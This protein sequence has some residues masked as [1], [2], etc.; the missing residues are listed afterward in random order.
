MCLPP[1]NGDVKGSY[2]EVSEGS[3]PEGQMTW[4]ILHRDLPGYT[5]DNTIQINYVFADGIQTV[6]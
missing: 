5:G 2:A 1:A 3:Q 4:V 6:S